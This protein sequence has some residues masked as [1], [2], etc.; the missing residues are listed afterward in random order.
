MNTRCHSPSRRMSS[1]PRRCRCRW[2]YR[3]RDGGFPRRTSSRAPS[4][5]GASTSCRLVA[6][7][8]R[9]VDAA[10]LAG[11]HTDGL[12][13][14]HVAHRIGL[15][16]LQRDERHDHV[17]LRRFRNFLVLGHHVFQQRL[18]DLEVV[19]ALLEGDAEDVLQLEFRGLVSGIDLDDVVLAL[20]LGLEDLERLVGVTGAMMPSDTSSFR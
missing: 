18:V 13:V 10:L 12:A 7:Q 4:D 15:G 2:R 11:A 6:R 5:A 9:T 8:A 19:V 17:D 14:L 20:L 16:I 3:G 1:P